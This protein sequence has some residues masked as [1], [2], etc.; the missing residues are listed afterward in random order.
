METCPLTLKPIKHRVRASDG[1]VYEYDAIMHWLENH[2]LSPL[3]GV[4]IISLY[5]ETE[6][7]E[8]PMPPADPLLKWWRTKK[9]DPPLLVDPSTGN[10]VAHPSAT[11]QP[12]FLFAATPLTNFPSADAM[13]EASAHNALS[14]VASHGMSNVSSRELLHH[15][16]KTVLPSMEAVEPEE[17]YEVI[18]EGAKENM[19]TEEIRAVVDPFEDSDHECP[20]CTWPFEEVMEAVGRHIDENKE[21][22]QKFKDA[23]GELR[24][25]LERNDG[26]WRS[27]LPMPDMT[28]MRRVLGPVAASM[29][30]NKL[31]YIERAETHQPWRRSK[32]LPKGPVNPSK[33]PEPRVAENRPDGPP[34]THPPERKAK[35]LP[36]MI[37]DL[38]DVSRRMENN[39]L[40]DDYL[41]RLRQTFIQDPDDVTFADELQKHSPNALTYEEA[42]KIAAENMDRTAAYLDAEAQKKSWMHANVGTLRC[43]AINPETS[44]MRGGLRE[45]FQHAREILKEKRERDPDSVTTVVLNERGERATKQE[46]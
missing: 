31:H 41:E 34:E 12:S 1:L 10:E 30:D 17:P 15:V 22:I 35:R 28:E 32:N 19:G 21:S 2:V 9:V 20:A 3:A 45:G 46:E 42:V 4:R 7:K 29:Q 23:A 39:T 14:G 33:V 36:K 13:A 43:S 18:E 25:R 11:L 24:V 16:T 8:I 6:N 40:P 37:V 27:G 38:H 26:L 5:D 44:A